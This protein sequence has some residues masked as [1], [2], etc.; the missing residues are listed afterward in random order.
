MKL[1]WFTFTFGLHL[2][3]TKAV[4]FTF[5]PPYIR[6]ETKKPS[7]PTCGIDL[8]TQPTPPKMAPDA[9]E[10]FDIKLLWALQA[11][12]KESCVQ[13]VSNWTQNT[14]Y[15]RPWRA[16]KWAKKADNMRFGL[17]IISY[18]LNLRNV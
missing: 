18:Y 2:L 13:N 3:Y 17:K 16:A 15:F 10:L 9:L 5:P 4:W 11:N 1:F 7:K 12:V 8:D 6:V 14:A